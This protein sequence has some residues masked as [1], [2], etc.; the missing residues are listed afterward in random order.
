MGN[1]FLGGMWESCIENMYSVYV[2]RDGAWASYVIQL[3][4]VHAASESRRTVVVWN[5]QYGQ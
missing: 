3:G 1:F 5:K 2:R 4:T